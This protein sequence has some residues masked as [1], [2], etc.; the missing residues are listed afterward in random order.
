MARNL[1]EKYVAFARLIEILKVNTYSSILELEFW[2]IPW[3]CYSCAC[4]NLNHLCSYFDHIGNQ[5]NAISSVWNFF[6]LKNLPSKWL[7]KLGK[8]TA[9]CWFYLPKVFSQWNT[10]T[11]VHL[12]IALKLKNAI[13]MN[14]TFCVRFV[15]QMALSNN[16]HLAIFEKLPLIFCSVYAMEYVWLIAMKL[17]FNKTEIRKETKKCGIRYERTKSRKCYNHVKLFC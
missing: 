16:T 10:H 1:N 13:E 15:Q 3:C 9:D 2:T 11:R 8:F 6:L 12:K 14:H 4:N 7:N 17:K 5:T